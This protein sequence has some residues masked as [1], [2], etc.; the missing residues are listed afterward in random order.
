[1]SLI[2]ETFP[3][4]AERALAVAHCESGFNPNAY[5]GKNT[6]GTTDGGLF[7]INSSHNARLEQ[8]GLDK[9][10]PEDNVTFARMLYDEEGWRPWVC[11]SKG[12]AYR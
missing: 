11:H 4:D 10:D 1:M 6:N 5:N 8:L 9:W 12:L 3:E 2:K 7:Q